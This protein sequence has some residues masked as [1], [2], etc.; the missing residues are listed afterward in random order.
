MPIQESKVLNLF[1]GHVCRNLQ[2][3]THQHF[4]FEWLNPR[5]TKT[6]WEQNIWSRTVAMVEFGLLGVAS[7]WL[8]VAILGADRS[9]FV[10]AG[11][12]E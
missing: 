3:G 1:L 10:D 11:F 4:T 7:D 5:Q 8:E 2:V 9:N 12:Q 6:F